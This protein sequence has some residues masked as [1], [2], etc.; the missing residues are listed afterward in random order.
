[1]VLDDLAAVR[2]SQGTDVQDFRQFLEL[3]EAAELRGKH[4]A[5]EM[6]FFFKSVLLQVERHGGTLPLAALAALTG[7]GMTEGAFGMIV[8]WLNEH[9]L[10]LTGEGD[11]LYLH[12][13]GQ[14]FLDGFNAFSSDPERWVELAKK[15][16]C[17][18]VLCDA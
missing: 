11:A 6:T 9:G 3:V 8:A 16:N 2:A 14:D 15:F 18:D 13:V 5:F 4:V 1:M 12:P 7:T 17:E 10:P